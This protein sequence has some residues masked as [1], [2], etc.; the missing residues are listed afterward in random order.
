MRNRVKSRNKTSI[1]SLS[2]IFTIVVLLVAIPLTVYAARQVQL[3]RQEAQTKGPPPPPMYGCMSLGPSDKKKCA[4]LWIKAGSKLTLHDRTTHNK[5]IYYGDTLSVTVTYTNTG[6]VPWEISS[7][8]VAGNPKGSSYRITF[9]PPHPPATVQ[10]G[11]SITLETSHTFNAPDIGGEWEIFPTATDK[12]GQVIDSEEK[13]KVWVDST[14]TALRRQELTEADKTTMRRVCANDK[15]N[16][17]CKDFC[18]ITGE[19]CL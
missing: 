9:Q 4:S 3:V 14:C 19:M 17:V 16:E 15:A 7:M 6:D 5:I 13:T 10:P 11:K 18:E 2:I 1:K 8:G 12:Y